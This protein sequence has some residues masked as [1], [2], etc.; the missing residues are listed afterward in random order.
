MTKAVTLLVAAAGCAG[1]FAVFVKWEREGREHFVVFLLL[2]LLVADTTL[3]SDQ[4][5]IPRG[6]FHPGTGALE[7]RLPE[8]VITVGL[9]ARLAVRGL[10]RRAGFPAL[11]WGAFAAWMA[12][13][14]VEGVL[15]HNDM[16]QLRYEAK[17][18][19]YVV[20]GYALAAGVPVRKYLAGP[21]LERLVRFSAVGA[22]VL[23]VLSAAHK[24]YAVNLPLIPLLH[25]GSVGNDTGAVFVAIGVV[26][27]LLELA[28]DRR[29]VLTLLC[30]VPLLL[31]PFFAGQRAVLIMAG[32]TVTV[33]VLVALGN[34]ARLRWRLTLTPVV[35][36]A[37]TIVGVVLAVSVIPAVTATGSGSIPL[38]SEIVTTFE[39][40]AKAESSQ[41][42]LSKWE[43]AWGDTQQHLLIGQGMGFE[44]TYYAVGPNRFDVTDVT[45]NFWL[46]LWLRAGLIGLVLFL[47][48]L[49]A[50][51][52]NGIAT[53]RIHRDPLIATL[54]LALLS[55]VVGLVARGVVES[56][57]E[58]YRVATLLGLTLGMLRAAVASRQDSWLPMV[59]DNIR[60][61]A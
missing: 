6:I 5:L 54:A 56:I 35:M 2:G 25:F 49:S 28:K 4:N 23:V 41:D 12:I 20:G 57:F 55:V 27:F 21:G 40:P 33:V 15:R 30:I 51:L 14:T 8:V 3:Y 46:D 9:L 34:T 16:T 17:G 1:L 31:S 50:S 48:A 47:L 13:A 11:A 38:K 22:T 29:N 43:V 42:R 52:V 58:K 60:E 37:L 32:A 24:S 26:G 18:I 53:W 61:G 36:V 10:P 7:L 45:D 39:S 44:Y 19:I 59:R